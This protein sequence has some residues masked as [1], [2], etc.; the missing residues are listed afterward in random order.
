[1]PTYDVTFNYSVDDQVFVLNTTE[2]SIK[3][4]TVIQLELNAYTDGEGGVNSTKKYRVQLDDSAGTVQVNEST[5]YA[6]YASAA[7]AL[8]T[9]IT[10]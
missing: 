10:A 5:V 4:G 3:R 8:E 2:Y 6:D 9:Y 7:T 1:M